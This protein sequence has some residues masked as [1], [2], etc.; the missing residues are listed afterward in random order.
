MKFVAQRVSRALLTV[1][2]EPV[3]EIGHGLVVYFGVKVGDSAK[4]AE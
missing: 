4:Q 3:S 2:G 1:G